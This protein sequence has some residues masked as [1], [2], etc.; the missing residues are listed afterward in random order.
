MWDWDWLWTDCSILVHV[1]ITPV[2]QFSVWNYQLYHS[3]TLSSTGTSTEKWCLEWSLGALFIPV[4]SNLCTLP[5]MIWQYHQLVCPFCLH[6]RI[7]VCFAACPCSLGKL[8]KHHLSGKWAHL[9]FLLLLVIHRFQFNLL[10]PLSQVVSTKAHTASLWC[11][12]QAKGLRL[13]YLWKPCIGM[14]G[15]VLRHTET[16]LGI[17]YL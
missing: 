16:H 7:S 9:G 5:F 13:F 15:K 1:A 17:V 14:Y 8:C 10:W 6:W 3:E 11:F 2:L 4:Y 12:C